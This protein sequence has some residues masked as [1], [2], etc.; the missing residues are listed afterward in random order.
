VDVAA[1]A[2]AHRCHEEVIIARQSH[3]VGHLFLADAGARR[4]RAGVRGSVGGVGIL[5][6]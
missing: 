3:C 5:V 1:F 6:V 4:I 2:A